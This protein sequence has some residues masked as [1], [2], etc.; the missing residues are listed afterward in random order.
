MPV[1]DEEVSG[2]KIQIIT[3]EKTVQEIGRKLS[4]NPDNGA[5]ADALHEAK[6]LITKLNLR[7]EQ[8]E[9]PKGGTH[10]NNTEDEPD[11]C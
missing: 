1:T 9:K 7:I 3:L 10:A 4:A 5:L 6:D 2:M 11:F 8:L